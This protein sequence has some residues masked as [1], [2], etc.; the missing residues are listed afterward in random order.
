MWS[1]CAGAA[2]ARRRGDTPRRQRHLRKRQRFAASSGVSKHCE[3]WWHI[4]VPYL[5]TYLQLAPVVEASGSDLFG[6]SVS[7]D[8]G[9]TMLPLHWKN[10]APPKLITHGPGVFAPDGRELSPAP[11]PSI[12]GSREFWLRLDMSSKSPASPLRVLNL[13]ITVGYQLNMQ[14][15]PRVMPGENT[16]SLEAKE[17]NGVRL[18]AEWVYTHP[19]GERV[20]TVEL[21]KSGRTQKKASCDVAASI[22]IDHARRKVSWRFVPAK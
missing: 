21:E 14:I 7:P 3:V 15:L 6:L 18:Q 8:A 20:E 11:S 13:G 17:L 1:G 9:K 5:I 22:K 2:A 4:K 10:G 19:K 12:R 16:L